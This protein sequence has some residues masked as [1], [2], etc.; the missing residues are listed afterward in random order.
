MTSTASGCGVASAT[1]KRLPIG[2]TESTVPRS[3][4]CAEP[5]SARAGRLERR[6]PRDTRSPRRAPRA[7]SVLGDRAAAVEL[8]HA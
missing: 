5:W 6:P 8:D 1:W 4:F 7:T 3:R 2:V